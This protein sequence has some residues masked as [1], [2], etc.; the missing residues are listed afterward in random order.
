[1]L[2]I[3]LCF[4]YFFRFS[5]WQPNC[6]LAKIHK[7]FLF[8]LVIQ[9]GDARGKLISSTYWDFQA[10]SVIPVPDVLY[11]ESVG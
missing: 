10:G 8:R 4:N 11:K 3:P 9:F 5:R 2:I 1:M 6:F 7:A